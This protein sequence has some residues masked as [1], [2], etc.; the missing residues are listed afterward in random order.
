MSK[1]LKQAVQCSLDELN[2]WLSARVN[3]KYEIEI[4]ATA[5]DYGRIT[6]T[7]IYWEAE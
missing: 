3:E 1:P 5:S 6:Y 2:E 7:V 4:L